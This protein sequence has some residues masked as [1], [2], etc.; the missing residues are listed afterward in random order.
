M[1]YKPDLLIVY[2][3]WNDESAPEL[4]HSFIHPD[5]S[6]PKKEVECA[7]LFRTANH[8]FIEERFK[9]S[10]S[11]L[12]SARLC[13]GTVGAHGR[14][15]IRHTGVYW[16]ISG[17]IRHV[18]PNRQPAPLPP[19]NP[20]LVT[21]LVRRYEDNLTRVLNIAEQNG[22]RV[23]LFLQPIM[24]IDGHNPTIQ[25]ALSAVA[26]VKSITARRAFYAEA[27]SMF[28]RLREQHQRPGRVCIEDVSQSFGDT[29]ETIYADSGHLLEAGNEIVADQIVQRLSASGMLTNW[30]ARSLLSR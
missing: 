18:I 17:L 22:V 21:T 14:A 3:G 30:S 10:F 15:A 1:N 27:R 6:G 23:A 12:G 13:A 11:V 16:F 20:A 4:A 5:S 9:A 19:D 7:N 2:D 25:E 24:W 8:L 26:D 29:A 28:A